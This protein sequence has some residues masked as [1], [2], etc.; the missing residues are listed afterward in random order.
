MRRREY[1]SGSGLPTPGGT[2]RAHLLLRVWCA[3][4]QHQVDIDP[5]EQAE[6]YGA[7]MPLFDWGRRLRC[8]QWAA[9]R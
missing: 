6:R 1:E 9:V 8:T 5:G 2:A 7:Q 3:D 4:C